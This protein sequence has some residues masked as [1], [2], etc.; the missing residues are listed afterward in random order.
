[1]YTK[2]LGE[3]T[4]NKILIFSLILVAVT[5]PLHNNL[6]SYAIVFFSTMVAITSVRTLL[7]F[8]YPI[9][10]FTSFAYF[11]W[12]ALTYFWDSSGGFTIKSLEGYAGLTVFPL[13][14]FVIRR[15]S[16][17]TVWHIC[18]AFIISITVISVVCLV[19]A[20]LQYRQTG[21]SRVFYY[22]YLSQ[23]MALN[24]IFLS[25]YCVAGICWF[26]YF[27]FVHKPQV[28]MPGKIWVIIW[29]SYLFVFV[30][31][32]S[33]KMVIFL[34]LGFLTFFLVYLGYKGRQ[35]KTTL[36]VLALV[37]SAAA[38]AI[39]NF[40]YLRWRLAVTEFKEYEGQTDDQN[41]LAA[42]LLMWRSTVELIKERPVAGYGLKGG[43][44]ALVKKYE[45]KKFTIGIQEKYH[46]HNQFLQTTLLSGIVGLGLLLAFLYLII[47]RGIRSK[48]TPLVLIFVHFICTSLVEST[49]EMQ[50]ELIF[51]VF[52]M[53][54]FYFHMARH[55][56]PKS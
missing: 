13:A 7:S 4:G 42:R 6:N 31:L 30:F 27:R 36:V 55:P 48:S 40:Y 34:L 25:N 19:M 35:L 9:I 38:L 37:M 43:N 20:Y 44:L 32:L 5:I 47:N 29:C 10:F 56:N 8:R 39:D 53:M 23:Q 17:K 21:D 2:L 33:S 22:H 1:M 24:A 49:L 15:Q 12:L 3:G 18:F 14:L 11:L 41:G 52:F 26:I 50:Q 45:E 28:P 54:L 16:A 51:F 46:A